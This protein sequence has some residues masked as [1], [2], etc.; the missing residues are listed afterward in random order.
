MSVRQVHRWLSVVF[1]I[2]VGI[3]IVLNVAQAEQAALIAGFST[4]GVLFA[5]LFTGWYLFAVPYLR[6]SAGK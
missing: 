2:A 1:T 6:G 5:L 4:L 3:N